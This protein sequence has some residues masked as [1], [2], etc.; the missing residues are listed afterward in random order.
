MVL[1]GKLILMEPITMESSRMDYFKEKEDMNFQ[2]EILMKAFSMKINFKETENIIL[3]KKDNIRKVF[4]RMENIKEDKYI[5][6]IKIF[7]RKISDILM[8]FEYLL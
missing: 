6:S 3:L 4:L 1:G 2:M 8:S 7:Q 5:S